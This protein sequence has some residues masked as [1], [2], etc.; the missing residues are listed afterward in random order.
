MELEVVIVDD[1]EWFACPVGGPHCGRSLVD[2][3]RMGLDALDWHVRITHNLVLPIDQVSAGPKPA[4]PK[5]VPT[6]EKKAS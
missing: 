3:G 6:Q 2:S 1:R 4:T 5:P